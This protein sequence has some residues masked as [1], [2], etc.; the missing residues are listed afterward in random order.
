MSGYLAYNL[1]GKFWEPGEAAE[2]EGKHMR[3]DGSETFAG[4]ILVLV[5]CDL[6]VEIFFLRS[7]ALN[8]QA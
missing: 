8:L 4:L 6:Y 7:F 3:W 1:G 2:Q 5:R